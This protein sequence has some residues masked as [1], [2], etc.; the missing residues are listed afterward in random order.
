[1]KGQMLIEIIIAVGVIALVLVGVG[2]LMTRSAKV[3]TFQK[4]RDEATSIVQKIL[5]D[6]RKQRDTNP[7]TFL[8]SLSPSATIDPCVPGK[9]YKCFVSIAVDNIANKALITVTAEWDDGGQTV[10]VSLSEELYIRTL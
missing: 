5:V 6:Y 4:Q 1:M 7:S 9:P 8:G 10:D 2:D 3:T